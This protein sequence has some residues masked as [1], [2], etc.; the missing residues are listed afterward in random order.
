MECIG[1]SVAGGASLLCVHEQYYSNLH[2]PEK[3]KH[4][5]TVSHR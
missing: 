5:P 1:I 3:K 2:K 4:V